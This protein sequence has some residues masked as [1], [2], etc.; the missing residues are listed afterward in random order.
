[1]RVKSTTSEILDVHPCEIVFNLYPWR[2]K[3]FVEIARDKSKVIYSTQT[4]DEPPFRFERTMKDEFILRRL[5]QA[6]YVCSIGSDATTRLDPS[7]FSEMWVRLQV[8]ERVVS[9]LALKKFGLKKDL[10]CA[11][12]EFKFERP[13]IIHDLIQNGFLSSQRGICMIPPLQLFQFILGY[14]EN[15]PRDLVWNVWLSGLIIEKKA[16]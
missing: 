9:E 3:G 14:P 10:Y 12:S 1:M 13:D 6:F 16:K 8:G 5:D 7:Y 11:Q 4:K 2:E 15:Y